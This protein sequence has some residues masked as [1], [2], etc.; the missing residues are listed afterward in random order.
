MDELVEEPRMRGSF[1]WMNR[2]KLN[3]L[4]CLSLSL[5]SGCAVGGR[6]GSTELLL[7]VDNISTGAL[8]T[9]PSVLEI[10]GKAAV[11]YSTKDGR[12][13]FQLDNQQRLLDDLARVRN[14]GSFFQLNANGNDLYASWWS[15]Q[16]G[17]NVYMSVSKDKGTHFGPVVAANDEHGIL[18]PISVNFAGSETVGLTYHD[19]RKPNYQ[20][21]FNRSVDAGQTWPG[22]DVRLDTP[23][24]D[25]RASAVFEPQTVTAKN[26]WVSAWTDSVPNPKGGLLYRIISRRSVDAGLTWSVAEVMH[27][28]DHH[29]SSLKIKSKDNFVVIVADE[30]TR[31]VFSIV[32]QDSGQNWK[33]LDPIVGTQKVTNSGIEVALGSAYAYT[34][35]SVESEGVKVRVMG[36][37]IDLLNQAWSTNPQRLDTKDI[38]NTMSNVPTILIT[39]KDVAVSTWIDYRDIRPNIYYAVSYDKGAAW[40]SPLAFLKP[41]V[42]SAGWPQLIKW[43]GGVAIA[44]ETYATDK[45]KEGKLSLQ[46]LDLPA[47]AA[48]LIG[49]SPTVITAEQKRQRLERRISALWD[50]RL[51]A[52]QAKAYDFF[53]FAYKSITSQNIYVESSKVIT[54]QSYKIADIS[55]SGNEASV[56]MNTRY[57]LKPYILPM[58][59]KSIK[60]DPVDAE[61][62]T[63]W[64]WVGDEWYFVYAPSFD[65]PFLRY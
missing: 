33:K 20:A 45:A 11:M 32:S 14:G 21:Y 38:E 10:D 8:S 3:L 59:G 31:G 61:V 46:Y 5:L 60:V 13:G 49:F 6:E 56:T 18:P 51:A 34:V 36:A 42:V 30:L 50:A 27:A 2:M 26:S 40:S 52:D 62:P 44:Y 22:P 12:V 9:R 24:S 43:K 64:V 55:I 35:W 57:E 28:T 63:K 65:Q 15:H 4:F 47:K 53:D 29:I 23:P 7:Q 1:Y 54:Y 37:G 48:D 41:G 17:K 16:D 25:A 58:T 39:D 19:E